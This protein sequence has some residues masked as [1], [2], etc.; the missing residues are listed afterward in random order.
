MVIDTLLRDIH[1]CRE[2]TSTS[3]SASRKNTAMKPW[4]S[5]VTLDKMRKKDRLWQLH[6]S[7][8]ANSIFRDLHKR[9]ESSLTN[10]EK[11]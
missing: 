1:D 9:A 5:T 11:S 10:V 2:R 6:K 8:P 3:S 7:N 4:I